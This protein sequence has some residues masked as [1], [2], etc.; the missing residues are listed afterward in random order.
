MDAVVL[1]WVV[2]AFMLAAAV[3]LLPAG[4]IAD[5]HG[6]KRVFL[7]G[8]PGLL[9][10]ALSLGPGPL[11]ARADRGAG[12]STAAGGHGFATGTA[13]LMSVVPPAQARPRAGLERRAVYLGL[14]LGPF[15]GGLIT[16]HLGWRWIF[17]LK[18]LRGPRRDVAHALCPARRVGR[19]PRRGV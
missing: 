4:R 13:I 7:W 15:L 19:C 1:G 3:C 12:P 8:M 16:H 17:A 18:R 11:R 5:L 14:S 10:S 2:M 9:R 6:R